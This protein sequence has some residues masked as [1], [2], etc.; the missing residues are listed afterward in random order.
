MAGMRRYRSEILLGLGLAL[1]TLFAFGWVCSARY[2]FLNLDDQIYVTENPR[3]RTGFSRANFEWAFVTFQASLWHPLTWLSLQLDAQ[4]YGLDARGF[5]LTNVLLHTSNTVL[6]FLALW[7]LTGACERSAVVAAFFAVHPLHVESVAWI[8]E[9][10][11]VLSTLFWMLSLLV[12]SWYARQPG[13]RVYLLLL[14]TF[15]LG[16]LAKAMLVTLPFVL[17]LLDNWPLGRWPGPAL[18][19]VRSA[20]RLVAEK[21]PLF[22][23]ALGCSAV[24]LLAGKTQVAPI[25]RLPLNARLA[26]VPL[27]YVTYLRQTIWPFDLAAFYPHRAAPY[28]QNTPWYLSERTVLA[29][30][31]LLLVLTGLAL[32]GARRYPYL[33]VGWLWYVGTLVPVIGLVQNGL[34]GHADRY[35]YVPLIGIFIMLAWGVPDLLQRWSVPRAVLGGATGVLLLLCLGLTLTQ[36]THWRNTTAL[37]E[38]AIAVTPPNP[39]AEQSLAILLAQQ[40]KNEAAERHLKEAIRLAPY[41]ARPYCHLGDVLLSEG[42]IKDAEANYRA[43]RNADP[44]WAAPSVSLGNLLIGKGKVAQA[45]AEFEDALRRE[46]GSPVALVGLGECRLR[47]GRWEEAVHCLRTALESDSTLWQGHYYLGSAL[48]RQDRPEEA[49]PHLEEFVQHRPELGPGYEELGEALWQLGQHAQGL[50]QFREAARLQPTNARAHANLAAALWELGQ[51][52]EADAEFRRADQLD[53]DWRR[54]ARQSAWTYATHPEA[55]Q[56]R[57]VEAVHLARLVCRASHDEGV[58]ELDTLAAAYAEAGR[59]DD[60]VRVAREALK[61]AESAEQLSQVEAIRARL[62]RYERHQPFR[63]NDGP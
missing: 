33:A 39:L 4:L 51:T 19:P 13:W 56:R 63:E 43:A 22:L 10:K 35:T 62:R 27:A 57:R 14:L 60:A 61:R 23:L 5:H 20:A 47:Q 48:R 59:F 12:Y 38:H 42:R 2:E 46:P 45:A 44:T 37:W 6:L 34:P 28:F 53:A 24:A 16:L 7:R 26:N 54:K 18:T 50:A 1:L 32:W 30:T 41:D 11:D 52:S 15:T 29:A 55:S 25:D 8:T 21:L 49:V 40:G 9:R 17:L 58:G 36:L 31:G 3:V